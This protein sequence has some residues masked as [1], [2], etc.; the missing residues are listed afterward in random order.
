MQETRGTEVKKFTL[1]TY[2]LE[3]PTPE[4]M[5]AWGTWFASTEDK[6]VDHGGP[7]GGG[8]KITKNGTVDLA[9][10]LNAFTGYVMIDAADLDEATEIAQAR[11]IVTSIEVYETRSM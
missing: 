11:P 2:G 6:M 9:F 10:D 4:I 1:L 7:T 8:R 3:Q 5:T